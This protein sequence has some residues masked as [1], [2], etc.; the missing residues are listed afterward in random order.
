MTYLYD[1][2]K[3]YYK[4]IDEFHERQDIK[5][6]TLPSKKNISDVSRGIYNNITL[7]K[8][9]FLA[10]VL[11]HDKF[12]DLDFIKSNYD[13]LFSFILS[14]YNISYAVKNED[15]HLLNDYNENTKNELSKFIDDYSIIFCFLKHVI[16][17]FR[18]NYLEDFMVSNG[19]EFSLTKMK[20]LFYNYLYLE[21][22][23]SF[24]KKDGNDALNLI[25]DRKDKITNDLYELTNSETFQ[26]RLYSQQLFYANEIDRLLEEI[27][28][29]GNTTSLSHDEFLIYLE[30]LN[31]FK[32]KALTY[33]ENR[34]NKS[35]K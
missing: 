33:Y 25:N 30:F 10:E 20:S 11:I 27:K 16:V 9:N 29:K 34:P 28:V 18:Q 21:S 24:Y 14:K 35:L 3:K 22:S 19:K 31:E 17:K 26:D 7:Y 13:K 12:I 23:Y 15:I 1:L 2:V 6:T 32:E 8:N 5:F 4:K